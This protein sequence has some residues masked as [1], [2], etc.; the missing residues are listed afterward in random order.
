MIS[1]SF[2]AKHAPS[3]YRLVS[4]GDQCVVAIDSNRLRLLPNL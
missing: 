3:F 4:D 2:E 1:E